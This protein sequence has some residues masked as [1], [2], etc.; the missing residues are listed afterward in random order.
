MANFITLSRIALIIPFCLAFMTNASWNMKAAF[1]LFALA[2]ITDFLDGWV[3]RARN[4]TSRLGAA[5]DPLADKLLITA[6]L[7]LLLRNGLVHG[8]GAIAVLVILLREVLVSGLREAVTAAGG[9][10][11][12]TSVAK[13]KTTAQ[14]LAAGTL[15][16]AS[17]TGFFPGNFMASTGIGLLWFAAILTFWTGADYSAKAYRFLTTAD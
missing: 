9:A 8:A 12:V 13:W 11:P 5:L 7:I 10:L 2:A 1:I 17:P 16:L 3:A 15:L 14:L 4:E 6:A